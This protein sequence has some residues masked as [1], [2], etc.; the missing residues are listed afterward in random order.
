[1]VTLQISL[2]PESSLPAAVRED[3]VVLLH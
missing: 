2:L 1:L 3:F